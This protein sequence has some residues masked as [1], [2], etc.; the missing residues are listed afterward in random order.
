MG[1]QRSE[2]VSKG[3]DL[4]RMP[5]RLK[6]KIHVW[7]QTTSDSF[8]LSVID[9]G[10]KISCHKVQKYFMTEKRIHQIID[11]C[12]QALS[13]PFQQAR[14]IACIAGIIM[15]QV[16]AIGP[17]ARIRTRSM[18]ACI[19][20]RLLTGENCSKVESYDLLVFV[21]DDTKKELLYSAS[22]AVLIPI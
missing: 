15:L 2:K 18:C 8:V 10:Y 13:R 4:P 11:M 19:R 1:V 20:I 16:S 9:G 3:Q 7:R 21:N 14:L 6:S 5:G 17:M 12:Q 22:E